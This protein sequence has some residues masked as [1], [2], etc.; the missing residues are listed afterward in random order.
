MN[1]SGPEVPGELEGAVHLEAER[2]DRLGDKRHVI[3]TNG[4]LAEMMGDKEAMA[5][6]E[7]NAGP[8][9]IRLATA[10]RLGK[11]VHY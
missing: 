3:G 4:S 7:E 6:L 9:P 2:I 1:D 5:Y 11:I 10:K 8:K